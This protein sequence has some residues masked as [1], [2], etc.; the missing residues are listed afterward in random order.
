MFSGQGMLMSSKKST[1]ASG[2]LI[3]TLVGQPAAK[4]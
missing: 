2:K 1:A 4:P 3:A